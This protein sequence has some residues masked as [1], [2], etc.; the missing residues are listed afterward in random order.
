ML[1]SVSGT[2]FQKTALG[3][4][5][6]DSDCTQNHLYHCVENDNP[7]KISQPVSLLDSTS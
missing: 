2:P 4:H 7:K 5:E 6:Q 1:I 3:S